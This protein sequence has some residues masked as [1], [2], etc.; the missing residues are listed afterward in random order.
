M[1]SCG[2]SPDS[3][4]LTDFVMMELE[5]ANQGNEPAK[6]FSRASGK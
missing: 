2:S 1:K 4:D 5:G 6:R 3:D